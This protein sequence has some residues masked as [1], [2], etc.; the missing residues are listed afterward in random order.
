M[1]PTVSDR[2]TTEFVKLSLDESLVNAKKALKDKSNLSGVV[3][4]EGHPVTIL[5]LNDFNEELAESLDMPLSTITSK[6][7][8][9]IMIEHDITMEDFVNDSAFTALDEGAHGAIVTDQ[10][11]VIGILTE[12]AIDNYLAQEFENAIRTKGD[13]G[14]ASLFLTGLVVVYC[15]EFGHRNELVYYSRHKPP[16]CKIEQPYIHPLKRRN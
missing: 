4:D 1:I 7:P 11:Q 9:G 6:L 3:L 5:T 15:E 8:P 13:S 10:G 12:N 14:S 16:N 2:M